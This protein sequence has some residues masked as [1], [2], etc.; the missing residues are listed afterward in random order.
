MAQLF[1]SP[2]QGSPPGCHRPAGYRRPGSFRGRSVRVWRA[3][4]R[5]ESHLPSKVFCRRFSVLAAVSWAFSFGRKRRKGGE[6]PQT[7]RL[8]TARQRQRRVRGFF[9]SRFI[10]RP[11]HLKNRKRLTP[12]M[13]SGTKDSKLDMIHSFFPPESILP[14]W[15]KRVICGI[16]SVLFG[17]CRLWPA[18]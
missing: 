13:T 9:S 14:V 1:F 5:A 4:R 8:V 6:V 16:S 17:S 12:M 18:V 3:D 7:R 15:K 2:R 11:T 10:S